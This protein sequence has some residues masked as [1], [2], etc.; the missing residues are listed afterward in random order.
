MVLY[1]TAFQY[2]H[3]FSKKIVVN[4]K[5]AKKKSLPKDIEIAGRFRDA[6]SED[7]VSCYHN[8]GV[9]VFVGTEAGRV[10]YMR[11]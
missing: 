9:I 1:T 10:C 3:T 7:M 11:R 5:K 4:Y 2:Y 6:F 8:I